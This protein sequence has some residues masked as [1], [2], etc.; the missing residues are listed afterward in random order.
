MSETTLYKASITILATI[1][2]TGTLQVTL[3][4]EFFLTLV[5]DTLISTLGSVTAVLIVVVAVLT[6]H[7]ALVLLFGQLGLGVGVN[8]LQHVDNVL[9][10]A[11]AARTRVV[12]AK[13]EFDNMLAGEHTFLTASTFLHEVGE[14]AASRVLEGILRN[15]VRGAFTVGKATSR[16]HDNGLLKHALSQT[17]GEGNSIRRNEALGRDNRGNDGEDSSTEHL[18]HKARSIVSNDR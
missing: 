1:R 12:G 16:F 3:N 11:R 6:D 2:L 5:F 13:G 14:T 7:L 9:A 18:D 17:R 15:K 10:S 4:L 8:E